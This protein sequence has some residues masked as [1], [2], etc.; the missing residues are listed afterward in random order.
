MTSTTSTTSQRRRRCFYGSGSFAL[1][2]L[3]SFPFLLGA[4]A[5]C[6]TRIV[7]CHSV[8]F[9]L[10]FNSACRIEAV[11][12]AADGA[13]GGMVDAEADAENTTKTSTVEADR[14]GQVENRP[15]RLVLPMSVEAT[16]I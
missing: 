15:M 9:F 11:L 3:V 1:E 13:A 16:Q 10:G 6:I 12:V 4:S 7:S 14:K 2:R 5:L 8:H